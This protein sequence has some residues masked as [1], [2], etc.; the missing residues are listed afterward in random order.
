MASS[1][2][3]RFAFFERHT[4]QLSPEVLEDLIPVES[5]SSNAAGATGDRRSLRTLQLSGQEAV[6]RDSVGLVVSTAALPLSSKPAVSSQDQSV[7]S[8]SSQQDADAVQAMWASLMACTSAAAAQSDQSI[9]LPSQGHGEQSLN[10]R[11]SS[12]VEVLDGLV[13]AFVTSR[14]TNL[15]H[16]FD[17]TARCNPP[18]NEATGTTFGD[19]DGWRGYFAPIPATARQDPASSGAPNPQDENILGLAACRIRSDYRPLHLACIS[20]DNL[21]VWEDPHLYLY[22]RKPL[23]TPSPGDAFI[24]AIPPQQQSL[25]NKSR[26]GSFRVVDI[27]PGMVAVGTDE[28]VV[29]LFVYNYSDSARPD[30]RLYL[31]IKAP[32]ASGMEV[33]SVKLSMG[34]SKASVFVAYNRQAPNGNSTQQQVSTAGICCYDVPLPGPSPTMLSAPSA[35]HDLDGR[36][37]GSSSLVDSCSNATVGERLT[38][39]RF[40]LRCEFKCWKHFIA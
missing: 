3:K 5:E 37:V 31:R 2:W 27:Q 40:F 39:V 11:Q 20:H 12:M 9:Q 21:V 18:P 7:K 38:V 10:N 29:F 15:V 13:L 28:G 33:V 6:S 26:D 8:R 16:C 24:Y 35:R 32:A 14:D 17:I 34:L 4:L 19:L 25:W 22:C 23:S 36:Y 30:L 1:R